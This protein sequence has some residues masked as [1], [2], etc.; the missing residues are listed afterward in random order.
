VEL[1]KAWVDIATPRAEA[2]KVVAYGVATESAHQVVVEALA[3]VR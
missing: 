1:P 2:M 3:S